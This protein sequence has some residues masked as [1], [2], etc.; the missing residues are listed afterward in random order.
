MICSIFQPTKQLR[1]STAPIARQLLK[2]VLRKN[3]PA[4]V[5]AETWDVK[6]VIDLLHAWGKSLT[7]NDTCL[8]LKTVMIISLATV[9]MPSDP[10]MLRITPKA[11]QVTEG[12]VTFQP[13]F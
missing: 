6:K 7:M 12:L 9:K 2:E 8:T 11:L 3:P 13:V 4:R 5:M 1:A 10:N